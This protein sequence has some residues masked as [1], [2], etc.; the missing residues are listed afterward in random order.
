M[1]GNSLYF[2]RFEAKQ[3]IRKQNEAKRKIWKTKRKEKYGSKKTKRNEE[4]REILKQNETKRKIWEAKR[5]EKI[6]LKFSPKHSRR[7]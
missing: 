4:K 7:K 2:F 5:S 1:Q 3:K 6:D